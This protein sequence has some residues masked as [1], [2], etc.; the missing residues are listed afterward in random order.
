M[1][2]KSPIDRNLLFS[3]EAAEVGVVG[4]GG[5]YAD[6]SFGFDYP[7]WNTIELL[8]KINFGFMGFDQAEVL[9]TSLRDP[10]TQAE[11]LE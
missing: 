2:S 1:T 7:N 9:G 8:A 11:R 4:S 10:A 5:I 6:G 3:G